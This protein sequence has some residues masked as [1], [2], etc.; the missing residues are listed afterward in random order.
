MNCLSYC[1]PKNVFILCSPL[2][3]SPRFKSM[4]SQ[5]FASIEKKFL[6]S[7]VDKKSNVGWFLFPYRKSIFIYLE[8]ILGS[9]LFHAWHFK[10]ICLGL[11]SV[12]QIRAQ[13]ALSIWKCSLISGIYIQF[14]LSFLLLSSFCSL[15]VFL[16]G[17]CVFPIHLLDT[18]FLQISAV[19]LSTFSFNEYLL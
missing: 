19:I 3:D 14:P 7:S 8:K 10:R 15:H 9:S 16:G 6:G 12:I 2:S 1:M 18:Y 17:C 11:S 4:P 5:N 13:W